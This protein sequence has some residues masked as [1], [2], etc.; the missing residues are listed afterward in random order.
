MA[1][2]DQNTPNRAGGAGNPVLPARLVVAAVDGAIPVAAG[3]VMITKAGAAAL[4][5]DSPPKHMDGAEL[6]IVSTT[7]QAH[8]LTYTPGFGGGTTSRD[9]ATWGGA[10]NDTL[11]LVAYNGIWWVK[12]A[13][14][15]SLG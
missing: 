8:T 14:N 12:S 6:T 2:A 11:V 10:I 5:I 1:I 3:T 9:V 7:A 15:V 4:T 13:R